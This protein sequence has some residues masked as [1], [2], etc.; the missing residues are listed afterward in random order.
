MEIEWLLFRGVQLRCGLPCVFLGSPTQGECTL[1]IAWHIDRG[2]FG[3]TRLDGLNTVLAVH[4]PGRMLETKW[5]AALYVDERSTLEQCDALANIFA[6]QAGGHLA[7]LA[8]YII[9][10]LG[11]KAVSIEYHARSRRRRMTINGLAEID[12]EAIPSQQG[13]EVTL[14]NMP[15]CIVPGI[16]AVVAKSKRLSNR[17]FGFQWEITEK[18]GFYSPFTYKG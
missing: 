5:K 8:P 16:L 9:E 2:N 1:L 4:S 18:N 12:I 14:A 13:T 7:K 11:V 10:I 17:D 15:F 6:G 3:M